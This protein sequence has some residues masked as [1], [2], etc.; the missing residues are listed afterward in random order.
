MNLKYLIIAII[1]IATAL[2]FSCS[3]EHDHSGHNHSHGH[4]HDHSEH[5]HSGHNHDHSGHN[6][7]GSQSEKHKDGE[8]VFTNAQAKEAGVQIE[9]VKPSDFSEVIKTGGEVLSAQGEERQIVATASGIVNYINKTLTDGAPVSAGQGL[10]TISSKGIVDGD[11]SAAA[12]IEYE[13]AKRNYE[14]AKKLVEDNIVSQRD[15]EEAKSRF[16]QAE[17]ALQ[18]VSGTAAVNGV[19]ISSPIS[20]YLISRLVKQ[21]EYVSVGQPIATVSQNRRLQ[22]RAEVSE[23]YYDRL[24]GISSANF[25]LPYRQEEVIKLSEHN[26]RMLSFGKSSGENSYYLPVIFEFDNIGNIVPG[27]YAEIYLLGTPRKNIISL[28]ISAITEE[29]GLYFVYL[30][31]N[32]EH[33]KKQ[34]V[35][36]GA[37]NGDRVEIISGLKE[38]DKVVVAGAGHIRLASHAGEVPHGHS[39]SH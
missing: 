3:N 19:S 6:H 28:P 33:Y 12:K 22:L 21:G 14:R 17:A 1:S 10:F 5:N 36:L 31:L 4:S 25:I 30:Q 26:G 15:Y 32:N 20:G 11:I 23:K 24:S 7:G 8:I 27:S 35:R 29:Q 38:G 39:H 2:F 34:E 18:T 37:S 16:E 13:A 9:I